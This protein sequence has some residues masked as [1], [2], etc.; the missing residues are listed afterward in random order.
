MMVEL[1]LYSVRE[2]PECHVVIAEDEAQARGI[3][4]GHRFSDDEPDS[5]W[6]VQRADYL[7]IAARVFDE[8]SGTRRSVVTELEQARRIGE[9]R[10]VGGSCS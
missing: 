7:A 8:G 4:F 9:P 6:P 3:A 2:G 5:A 10:Y 1:N